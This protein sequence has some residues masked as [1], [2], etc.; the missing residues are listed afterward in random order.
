[1][2]QC[3]KNQNALCPKFWSN[4]VPLVSALAKLISKMVI[5]TFSITGRS[6][7]GY[8]NFYI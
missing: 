2:A 4:A 1:M 7:D 5:L 8:V 6:I 3:G